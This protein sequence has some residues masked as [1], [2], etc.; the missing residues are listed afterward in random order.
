MSRLRFID[1]F[2]GIGGFHRALSDIGLECVFASEINNELR[3]LYCLNFDMKP[4]QVIG[5]IRSASSDYAKKIPDH[6]VLCAG[7]PC[8]PFSKSGGQLGTRDETRGTLFHEILSILKAK[9]PKYVILENVGNF[10]RH[11]QGRTWRVVRERLESLGYK[12]AG[13]EHVTPARSRDW[14]DV[15]LALSEGRRTR[16]PSKS[17]GQTRGSGLIS[18]HHFGH[19]HH[20][21]RFFVVAAR[22]ELPT[23]AFPVR[24]AAAP[25]DLGTLVLKPHELDDVDKRE[26]KPTK[27]QLHCMDLWNRFIKTLPNDLGPRGFPLWSDEFGA[28]YPFTGKPPAR[29]E[30]HELRKHVRK[31]ARGFGHTDV[32]RSLSA[33][34]LLALL[35]SYARDYVP[36]FRHWKV[37]FIVQNRNW[38]I[39]AKSKAP[40]GWLEDL[41]KLPSSLRKLEWNVRGGKKDIF[42]YVLQFR[43]SGLR[44]KRY[45]SAPALVAMTATQIPFLGPEGR[46][47]ARAEG[48]L[49][50][51]FPKNHKL[52]ESREA[53]FRALGNA[54]HVDVVSRIASHLLAADRQLRKQRPSEPREVA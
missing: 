21:E 46:F 43:P 5:D 27:Q 6:D 7:F 8:Q 17:E 39:A 19:P 18:P 16:N 32:P 2:A 15:G 28:E 52:P 42:L 9:N 1:L 25:T 48:L 49:L 30:L 35:P 29:W 14:R 3:S 12:V 53:A 23:P 38:W 4:E 20:R 41:R 10:G 34:Q 50:Q 37:R 22:G 40:R 44:V 31:Y 36:A 13:T 24:P 26:T 51:G 54:V 33:E 11:D 45:T 47:L